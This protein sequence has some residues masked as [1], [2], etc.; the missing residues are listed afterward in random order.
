MATLKKVAGVN[1]VEMMELKWQVPYG[2]AFAN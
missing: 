2:S 1:E